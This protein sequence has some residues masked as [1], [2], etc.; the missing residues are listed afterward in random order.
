MLIVLPLAVFTATLASA[1]VLFMDLFHAIDLNAPSHVLKDVGYLLLARPSNSTDSSTRW[2]AEAGRAGQGI[3]HLQLS[4]HFAIL[5]GG[6]RAR[7]SHSQVSPLVPDKTTEADFSR[8]GLFAAE[9]RR[10]MTARTPRASGAPEP[11]SFATVRLLESL[12]WGGVLIDGAGSRSFNA[13]L[14]KCNSKIN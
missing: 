14:Q 6:G 2:R 11:E 12:P 7:A 8:S 9:E 10:R 5:E 3:D 13:S 1:I 4:R